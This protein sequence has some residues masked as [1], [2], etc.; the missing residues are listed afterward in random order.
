MASADSWFIT[1]YQ[2]HLIAYT[3]LLKVEPATVF[4]WGDSQ[5]IIHQCA[6]I[7]H[8]LLPDRTWH[9]DN[10]PKVDYGGHL[11]EG[12]AWALLDYDAAHPP[13][14]YLAEAM[15]FMASSLL[16]LHCAVNSLNNV[17][18]VLNPEFFTPLNNT[19]KKFSFF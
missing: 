11:G 2:F 9:K 13:E 4:V 16:L 3:P 6:N 5:K 15:G 1:E 10:D 14:G 18:Q 7:C 17:F 12:R 19:P 8:Y